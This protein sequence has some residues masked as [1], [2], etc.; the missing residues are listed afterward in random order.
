VDADIDILHGE[1]V[2]YASGVLVDADVDTLHDKIMWFI[3]IKD[4]DIDIHHGTSHL[5]CMKHYRIRYG[6]SNRYSVNN[7]K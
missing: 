1:I 4:I 7:Q 6:T 5:Y 3:F 2:E